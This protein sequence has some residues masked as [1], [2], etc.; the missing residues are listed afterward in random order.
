MN[1]KKRAKKIYKKAEEKAKNDYD[2][3]DLA[4]SIRKNLGD[5]KWAKLLDQKVK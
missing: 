1:D 5:K 3:N 2:F 4:E